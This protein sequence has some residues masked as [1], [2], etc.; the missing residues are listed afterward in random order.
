MKTTRRILSLSLVLIAAVTMLFGLAKPV[1]AADTAG[2]AQTLDIISGGKSSYVVVIPE[3]S[4]ERTQVA[5]RKMRADIRTKTR[6]YLSQKSDVLSSGVKPAET[7]ILIGKTNRPESAEVLKDVHYGEYAIRVVNKKI[8]IAA[9]DDVSLEKGCQVF[10]NYICNKYKQGKVLLTSDDIADGVA[11]EV[12]NA[13]PY[14]EGEIAD[15]QCVDLA[16]NSYMLYVANT[17]RAEFV[18]YVENL[19]DAGFEEFSFREAGKMLYAIYRNEEIILH[20]SFN[21]IKKEARVAADKAYDMTLF[22]ETEYKKVC[23]PSVTMVGVEHEEKSRD[24]QNGMCLIFR[25]EDGRFIIVDSGHRV[26]L[27][28]IYNA[29]RSLHGKSGKITVA[30]WI[31]THQHGDHL[32]GFYSLLQ[33]DLQKQIR[34]ENFIH[35]FV[36]EDQLKLQKEK[37]PTAAITGM[38]TFDANIIKAH[39]GQIIKAGGVEIEMLFTYA[40]MEPSPLD[41]PNTPSLVFRVTAQDNSVMVLGDASNRALQYMYRVYGDYLKSDMVQIAHHGYNGTTGLYQKIDADV[42]LWPVG[43]RQFHGREGLNALKEKDYN[44][45]ALNLAEEAYIAGDS[46]FTLILPYT[47][48]DNRSVR[49]FD[50]E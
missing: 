19:A 17:T 28:A 33:S 8:V 10:A 7:E 4:S 11:V 50:G 49:I 23:E 14:Y 12:L 45:M 37:R 36:R 21:G 5:A 35:H 26:S 39:S 43:I 27:D 20:A 2:K 48:K 6:A 41:H 16:D 1:Q 46:V 31:F 40:D 22:T 32:G 15:T 29:L 34:V 38:E 25:L 3:D 30:A 24:T 9:W 44:K 47:P 42:V 18:E 13:I